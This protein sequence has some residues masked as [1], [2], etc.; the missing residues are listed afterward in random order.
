MLTVQDHRVLRF[1]GLLTVASSMRGALFGTGN[2]KK[3]GNKMGREYLNRYGGAGGRFG[4]YF[5][6][7]CANLDC[8]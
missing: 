5:C 3:E 4:A 8:F 7:S 2:V 6:M 1:R